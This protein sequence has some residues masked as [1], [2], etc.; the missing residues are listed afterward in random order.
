[1]VLSFL[2]AL[3]LLTTPIVLNNPAVLTFAKE[4]MVHEG[5][6]RKTNEGF[7]YVKVPNSYIFETLKLLDSTTIEHPAYFGKSMVGAHI[8]VIDKTESQGKKLKLPPMG[9]IIPF[10]I[11]QFSSVDITNDYGTKRVYM[12][13]VDAAELEKIRLDNGLPPKARG[14]D[15]HITVGVEYL[16][17]KR[18]EAPH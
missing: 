14:L 12:F 17:G 2:S 9:T 4:D 3:F 16:S 10:E 18:G 7:V 5:P 1:M 13:T 15:F 6:L 11:M 8:T